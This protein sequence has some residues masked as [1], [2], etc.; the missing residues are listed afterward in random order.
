MSYYLRFL[1][2]GTCKMRIPTPIAAPHILY[3]RYIEI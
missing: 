1:K 2:V 3:T